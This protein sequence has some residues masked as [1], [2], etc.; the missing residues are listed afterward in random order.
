MTGSGAPKTVLL[1]G[2]GDT[3]ADAL[4]AAGLDVGR[5]ADGDAALRRIRVGTPPDVVV[6]GLHVSRMDGVS[7]CRKLRLDDAAPQPPVVLFREWPAATDDAGLVLAL[8]ADRYVGPELGVEGI[9]AAVREVLGE[10]APLSGRGL[11]PS[12][13]LDRCYAELM[14]R[15]FDEGLQMV[16][17]QAG[18][19]RDTEARNRL[20]V[21]HA[22]DAIIAIDTD[23]R[24]LFANPAAGRLTGYGERELL[25]LRITDL[26]P[27]RFRERHVAGLRH[28][29]STGERHMR[30]WRGAPFL[31]LCRNGVEVPVEVS[32]GEHRENGAHRFVGVIRDVSER[33]QSEQQ[34]QRINRMYAMLSACNH[35]LLRIIE[36]R[37]LL[38]QFTDTVVDMGGY[39]FAWVGYAQDDAERLVAPMARSGD[40][41]GYLDAVRVAWS[42][43]PEG[44]GPAGMAIRGGAPQVVADMATSRRMT[45]WREAVLSRG[46]RAMV[47]L[48]MTVEGRR[49]GVLCIYSGTPGVFSAQE[50][51]LL[52]AMAE[53]LAFRIQALRVREARERAEAELRLS[54][55]ALEASNNGVIITDAAGGDHPVIY[56]N[57]AF[58]RITGYDRDEIVGR[59]PRFIM[60]AELD[61][62]GLDAIRAAL[63]ERRAG[64]ATVR[65]YRRDG[66]VLWAE[67]DVSP[68]F[69]DDGRLT[70]YVGISTDISDRVRYEHELEYQSNHDLLT[71]LANRSLLQDRLGQALAV[72]ERHRHGV[73]VLV[74]DLDRFKHVNDTLGHVMGDELLRRVA[75]CL[76]ESIGRG[77]TLG[78]L[79]ADEFVVLLTEQRDRDDALAAARRLGHALGQVHDV[80]GQ[81]IAAPCS[82]GVS[83]FPG[84]GTQPE[85]LLRHAE[86]AMFRA[87][88]M[89]GAD[90]VGFTRDLSS[91]TSDRLRLESELRQALQREELQVFY[92]PQFRL[93]D[94]RLAGLE[95]LARWHHE[96][97]GWV[98]P[99]EFIP[100]AEETG[101]IIALGRLVLSTACRQLVQWRRGG[102]AVPRVAVNVSGLQ[103]Q[104]GELEA[105][106]RS[107][108]AESGLDASVLELEITESFLMRRAEQAIRQLHRLSALGVHVAIDDFGT[109]YSSLSYLKRL[110]LHR[111]KLDKSFVRDIPGNGHDEAIA[112]AVIALGKSMSLEVVAEGVEE[113]R[114]QRFL[115]R[116]GC[117][118]GQGFLYSPPLPAAELESLLRSG[119][120]RG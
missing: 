72:A 19:L 94:G 41:A 107:A 80:L 70:H 3:V 116:E 106:V 65:T 93:D 83:Y 35:V 26:I 64:S 60:G 40:D 21:E 44:G 113:E 17:R 36:E 49:L 90:V 89:G 78:R 37:S 11:C 71:G 120:K 112:R 42:D 114:Q 20:V 18:Q 8:G 118:V 25:G 87:K 6:S 57:P 63:R 24:I 117:D 103:V 47:A 2:S 51:G 38:Q 68:V 79:G 39:R 5:C 23:D 75:A 27:E 54:N 104:R 81:R 43:T 30:S 109:G 46:Y 10:G 61:Q 86:T 29:L 99:A 56:A 22:A 84:D 67:T 16:N 105:D 108:L 9:V 50:V 82:V 69:D 73:A 55:R 59:N 12:A 96:E 115:A 48:P 88:E 92:Q 95:A 4:R 33:L 110:P 91:G 98:S 62:P 52:E 100:L 111:L 97:L 119:L 74:L 85:E 102:I 34:L 31:L 15:L 7:L 66:S 76:G 77:D 58:C 13:E 53:D 32:F 45:P 14:R 1:V 101:L 28:Y